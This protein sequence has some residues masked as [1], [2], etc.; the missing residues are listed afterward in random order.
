MDNDNINND[1][2]YVV[3]NMN[4]ITI[5]EIH[6]A[7]WTLLDAVEMNKKHPD[8]F[9][10]PTGEERNGLELGDKV[11]LS[12]ESKKYGSERMWVQVSYIGDEE[13]EGILQSFPMSFEILKHG[14]TIPF[15]SQNVLN[16]NRI[17]KD[18]SLLESIR[19][20][21]M[22]KN[23]K[24]GSYYKEL[25]LE[26]VKKNARNYHAVPEIFR[27]KEVCF[28]FIDQIE[29]D[30]YFIGDFDN[31]IPKR[32]LS[33]D[34]VALK[35]I[36]KFWYA[37]NHLPKEIVLKLDKAV[38]IDLAK[39]KG[40]VLSR[41]P[42]EKLD[43]DIILEGVKSQGS[44]Y[45]IPL[46]YIDYEVCYEAV[47]SEGTNLQYCPE[48]FKDKNLCL[49]AIKSENRASEMKSYLQ[50]V[51]ELVQDEEL[52]LEAV[53]KIKSDFEFI[54]ADLMTPELFQKMKEVWKTKQE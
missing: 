24:I 7:K 15:I 47:K 46:E 13:Y 10:I 33:D 38:F 36:Q 12:F 6:M 2:K 11:Y 52:V 23:I 35:L 20:G 26:A 5:G 4:Y 34:E 28:A 29:K 22:L 27:D 54:R 25:C 39:R 9:E 14:D 48:Q 19:R 37:I 43:R 3:E 16:I 8:T 53:K 44:L 45:K 41:I 30:T 1:I 17:I 21:K 50:Y 51:P 42:K 40:Q 31:L 32:L 18:E 49:T